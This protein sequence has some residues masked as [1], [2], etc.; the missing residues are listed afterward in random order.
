MPAAAGMNALF[1]EPLQVAHA[2]VPRDEVVP[3]RGH[4]DH[5]LVELTPRDAGG[6]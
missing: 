3:A 6:E 5:G 4:A 1:D 2:D